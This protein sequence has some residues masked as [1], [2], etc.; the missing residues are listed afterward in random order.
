[1]EQT[2][3][4]K[5]I[6]Y[7][8]FGG[9]KPQSV[10]DCIDSWKKNL[11]DYEIKC[12][13]DKNFDVNSVRWVKEAIEMKKWSL[14]SDYIRHYALYTEGGIYMDTD[15]KVFKSLDEFLHWDFFTSI[16]YHPNHFERIGINQVDKNGHVIPP[17]Q[18]VG[19][20]GL[21]AAMIASKKGLPFIKECM[22]FFG[23]R[24]FIQED[25]SLFTKIINPAVMADIATR[26]GFVY[27]NKDQLLP[28]NMMIYNASV[29]ASNTR[30]RTKDSYSMHFAD[31]SWR[32]R[33]L[34]NEIKY[35]IRKFFVRVH[36]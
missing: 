14:A 17:N 2:K 32:D 10:I 4:P 33:T 28:G 24:P 26:Y 23:N 13:N 19:G 31:G 15:V 6:H 7:V 36:K 16:E 21:L 30:L 3:I 29:F 20:Y 25:G 12:W 5:L 35:R 8:W 27:Q 9:E 1:M 22:D 11:P 18:Y 34:F